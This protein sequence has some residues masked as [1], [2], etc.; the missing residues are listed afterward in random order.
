MATLIRATGGVP[1]VPPGFP[2]LFD[3][4]LRIVEPAFA[5]LIEIA[6]IPGRSHAGETVRTYAEHLHDWFD[7]LEQ[8]KLNWR[9]VDERMVAAYRNRMLEGESQHTGRPYGRATVNARVHTVCRFYAWAHRRGLITHLPFGRIEVWLPGAARH[10][11]ATAAHLVEGDSKIWANILTVPEQGHIPRPLRAAELARLLGALNQPYRLMAE[12]A[13]TTGLRRMEL[14]ALTIG[15][16]P[17]SHRLTPE[18]DPLVAMEI[19]R[20]KGGRPR[21]AYPPL[22]LVD[23]TLWYVGEERAVATRRCGRA[24]ARRSTAKLFLRT[25]GEPPTHASVSAVFGRAF[26]AAGLQGSLHTLRHTF[27]VTMLAALQRRLR[28]DP[29]LN[30]LKILQVLLGHASIETTALYL[31]CVELHADSLEDSVSHL[32]GALVPDAT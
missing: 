3:H 22:R 16:L 26:D 30:P 19:T 17:P 6:T 24:D 31:R 29:D 4:A 18:R 23:R 21:T 27:A 28:I 32:Y 8:S 7:A 25:S 9:D 10:R 12:W 11:R 5:Y 1:G 2:I 13:V 15:Q 20:T 14:C